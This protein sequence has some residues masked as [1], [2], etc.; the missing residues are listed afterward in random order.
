[1][2]RTAKAAAADA[3]AAQHDRAIELLDEIREALQDL[4]APDSKEFDAAVIH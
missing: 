4:P 3:Y 1:M 2:K